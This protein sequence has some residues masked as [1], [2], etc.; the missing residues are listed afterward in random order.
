MA[1]HGAVRGGPALE[2]F[3]PETI[4]DVL[5]AFANQRGDFYSYRMS[6]RCLGESAKYRVREV[7]HAV[8]D[9][10]FRQA[11]LLR[12][13]FEIFRRYFPGRIFTADFH[14]HVAAEIGV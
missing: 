6:N 2:L 14:G 1:D 9:D 3:A 10:G 11:R 4:P 12:Q 5:A 13:P 8:L 7:R